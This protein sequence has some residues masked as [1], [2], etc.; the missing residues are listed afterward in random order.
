MDKI[1]AL[2]TIYNHVATRCIMLV[3]LLLAFLACCSASSHRAERA[4]VANCGGHARVSGGTRHGPARRGPCIK[5]EL[6][7]TY[8]CPNE[9]IPTSVLSDS[10]SIASSR[11]AC[12]STWLRLKAGQC[13]PSPRDTSQAQTSLSVAVALR[14][15]SSLVQSVQ[16][17]QNSCPSGSTTV[18][19]A[20]LGPPKKRQTSIGLESLPSVIREQRTYL[21]AGGSGVGVCRPAAA[22]VSP[23]DANGSP[24]RTAPS[25]T[26][27]HGYS[28]KTRAGR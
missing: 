22:A 7:A 16:H 5:G 12:P 25:S 13:S 23:N 15:T 4:S 6:L 24:A 21:G 14:V 26:W 28:G 17:T 18:V 19:V 20:R 9:R 27:R 3:A 2:S 8:R 11:R 1:I 10:S